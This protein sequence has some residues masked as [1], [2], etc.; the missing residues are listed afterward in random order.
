MRGL[1]TEAFVRFL[2]GG[3]LDTSHSRN[4]RTRHN[5]IFRLY[6]FSLYVVLFERSEF[7]IATSKKKKSVRLCGCSTNLGF[8]VENTNL[9]NLGF[10][11]ENTNLSFSMGYVLCASYVCTWYQP[12]DRSMVPGTYVLRTK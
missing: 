3:A 6:F 8:S 4:I 10:S 1:P 9:G 7:L 5:I 2:G 12:A 11:V